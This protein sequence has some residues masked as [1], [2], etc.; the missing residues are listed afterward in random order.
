M[1]V[2]KVSVSVDEEILAEVRERVGKREFSAYLASALRRQLQR[3]RIRDLLDEMDDEVGPVSE[4]Q[5]DEARALWQNL[6][7]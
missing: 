2:S 4:G 1:A 6:A 5:L 3:D 7:T